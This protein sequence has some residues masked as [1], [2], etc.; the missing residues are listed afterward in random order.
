MVQSQKIDPGTQGDVS[1]KIQT[2]VHIL[3][4]CL[5]VFIAVIGIFGMFGFGTAESI[6]MLCI[7]GII[8]YILRWAYTRKNNVIR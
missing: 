8:D 2:A 6:I 4:L 3:L 5:G 7:L 1:M